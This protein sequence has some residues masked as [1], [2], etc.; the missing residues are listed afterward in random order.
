MQIE[1]GRKQY[2]HQLESQQRST[3]DITRWLEWFL[4]CLG[5]AID[6]AGVTIDHVLYKA[7]LWNAI[8]MNPVNDRQRQILGRMLES[9]FE[10]FMNTSKYAKL[11]KCSNDTALRDLQQLRDWGILIQNSSGGRSTSYRLDSQLR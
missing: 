5:R 9:G 2:Y 3:P 6:N 4:G 8:N 11:A 10:G 1:A 7:Q